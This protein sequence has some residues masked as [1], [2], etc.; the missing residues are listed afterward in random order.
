[1]AKKLLSLQPN[2]PVITPS[3]RHGT[4]FGKPNFPST[5]N[6]TTTLT[7]LITEDSWFLFHILQ[8]D[9]DFLHE[10][11]HTWQ[12]IHSY[13]QGHQKV[14]A[15]NVINDCAERGV[16]LTTDFLS[17]AQG[18]NHFQNV[19]QVVE[20]NQKELPNIRKG[21]KTTMT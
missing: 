16:K 11:S 9:S 18:E 8:I 14:N 3:G 15:I 20:K 4:G 17:S 10:G 5:L 1:M 2:S 12:D 19:L 6:A 13:Q 21:C 7:D